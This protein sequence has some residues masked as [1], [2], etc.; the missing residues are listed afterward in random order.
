MVIRLFAHLVFLTLLALLACDASP[1]RADD[2]EW[3]GSVDTLASG[4]VVVRNP[5][6]PL[7]RPG[8]AWELRERL[9]VGALDGDG[10][11]VFGNI[12]DVELGPDGA[13]YVLDA[14]ASEVRV[15]GSDGAHLRT[16]GRRGRG[17]GEFELA[18]GMAVE[19]HGTL[20]VM[21]WGNGRYSGFDPNTG[22]LVKEARRLAS[23]AVVPWPGRFDRSNAAL[24]VGLGPDGAPVI[25]GLDSAFVPRDTLPLPQLDDAFQVTFRRGDVPVMRM[26]VPFAPMPAWAAHPDGGIVVGV[27]YAYRLHRIG[28]RG[29]TLLTIEVD[30]APVPVTA[31]ERDSAIGDFR[32]MAGR[33]AGATPDRE[34]RVPSTK[35]AHGMLFVDD[36]SHIW[37]RRTQAVGEPAA[38][39][40]FDDAGRL[41][42]QVAIPVTPAF[43]PPAV[44]GDRVAVVA[45]V[46]DVPMVIVYDIFRGR[47]SDRGRVAQ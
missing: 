18:A 19:A 44:R 45:R 42:G 1:R 24:D 31:A 26:P 38:W 28:F 35:P 12:V 3:L 10:A 11:D 34:P 4:R 46:D 17:P 13:L 15:F 40:V 8:E 43:T 27:G 32:E 6:A 9:R 41:L 29:D 21:D 25:L 37:V 5:D 23:F 30:R 14:H 47:R 36:R 39:D 2:G 7:W 16:F 20:W 22:A 33:M